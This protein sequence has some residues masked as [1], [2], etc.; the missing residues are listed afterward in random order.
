MDWIVTN[1]VTPLFQSSPALSS[2]RYFAPSDLEYDDAVFQSSPALSSGRYTTSAAIAAS[3]HEFQSSPALS[4]GRY[5]P[6]LPRAHG[7]LQVSILARPFERAL[8]PTARMGF[9]RGP[10]FNPRP[11]FRAGATTAK[12]SCVN[13][14]S[15]FQ[16]SPALSSGRYKARSTGP[17]PCST[18]F[19][20]R[21]PFRAGATRGGRRGGFNRPCFN[22]RPPFRAG[23][24]N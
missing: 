3:C 12:R 21:P 7:H 23:A 17:A 1:N 8:R 11:P 6:R 18:R 14:A 24:T 10:C 19:N 4:S 16:S 9:L 13:T 5:G 20:P 2:G 22:P 15:A